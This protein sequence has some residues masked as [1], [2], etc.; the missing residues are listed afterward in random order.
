[1]RDDLQQE[2]RG[3][4]IASAIA[5]VVGVLTLALACLGIFGV[6]SYGVALRTK[7]IGIRVALG[8]RHPAL[9]GSI[10]R[11]VLMPVGAGMLIGLILAIPTG[12]VLGTE[13]F[14]LENTDPVAFAFSLVVLMAA[15][16]AAALW[17]AYQVLQRNPVDALRHS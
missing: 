8:A 14:Y 11:Q 2:L 3:P 15:G 10:V 1:M 5:A 13:P 9:L 17:P 4:R 12:M 6:V 16:A 7:E